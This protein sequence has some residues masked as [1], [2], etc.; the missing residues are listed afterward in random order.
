[1]YV[2]YFQSYWQKNLQRGG[3]HP[4]VLIGLNSRGGGGYPLIKV[5][6]DVR[7]RALGFAGVNFCSGIRLWKVNFA[8]ALGFSPFLTKK[9]AI[10]YERVKKVTYLLKN[11]NFGTLRFMKTCPVIR[12]WALFCRALG[13]LEKFCPALAMHL[14]HI[15]TYPVIIVHVFSQFNC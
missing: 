15:R 2:Y 1:M 14:P 5:G 7:V 10:F 6:T 4:P 3:K 13:V 8:Q 9:C 12:F 11:S